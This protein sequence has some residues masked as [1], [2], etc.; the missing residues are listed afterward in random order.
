MNYENAL[1]RSIEVD[2][3]KNYPI[4]THLLDKYLN[5]LG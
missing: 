2:K 4:E 3:K 5:K 1:M